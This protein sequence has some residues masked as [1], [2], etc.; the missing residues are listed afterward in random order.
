MVWI[1]FRLVAGTG[2]YYLQTL[3]VTPGVLVAATMVGLPAAAVLVVNNYRDLDP[4]VRSASQRSR[5]AS[6]GRS[7]AGNTRPDAVPLLLLLPLAGRR[8]SARRC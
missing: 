4:V 8:A 5:S 7:A 3:A 6:A 1:F 2:S